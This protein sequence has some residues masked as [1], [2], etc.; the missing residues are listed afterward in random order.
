MATCGNCGA[1]GIEDGAAFCGSCGS[2][3]Q[4]VIPSARAGSGPPPIVGPH[5]DTSGLPQLPQNAESSGEGVE[6]AAQVTIR[7]CFPA[8]A[9]APRSSAWP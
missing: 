4:A 2:P 3:L 8:R 9:G 6:H 1:D 5:A 7:P